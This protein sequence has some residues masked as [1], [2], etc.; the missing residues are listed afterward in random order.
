ML[1]YQDRRLSLYMIAFRYANSQV[2]PSTY[3]PFHLRCLL[4]T[5]SKRTNTNYSVFAKKFH[6]AISCQDIFLFA[7]SK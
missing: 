6:T 1:D 5:G 4:S 2:S 7:K 3:H